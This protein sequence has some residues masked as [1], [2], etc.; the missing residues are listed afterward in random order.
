M[1][2]A[3]R[4]KDDELCPC[5]SGLE[6][7]NCCRRWHESLAAPDALALMK[8]RYSAFVKKREDYLLATWHRS[9]C[10]KDAALIH[11]SVKWL[12][13]EVQSFQDS[14]HEAWVSFKARGKDNGRFFTMSETSHFVKEDGRWYYLDGEVDIE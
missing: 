8:S 13:L 10:P 9:T 12:G 1:G 4:R 3:K 11:D 2:K 6:Y 5:D 7:E 14:E